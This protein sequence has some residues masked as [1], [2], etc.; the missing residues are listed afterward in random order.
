MSGEA[1]GGALLT[2]FAG[3]PGVGKSTL[4]RALQPWPEAHL[5]VNTAGKSPEEAADALRRLLANG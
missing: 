4:A 2:I 5:V 1:G 3:L